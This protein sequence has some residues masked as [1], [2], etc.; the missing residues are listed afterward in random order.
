MA[1]KCFLYVCVLSHPGNFLPSDG[2]Q[3]FTA[4]LRGETI[5]RHCLV[6]GEP[7]RVA[8][9]Q[10]EIILVTPAMVEA[11]EDTIQAF[12]GEKTQPLVLEE[13]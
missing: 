12:D 2:F 8:T 13:G 6:C 4:R 10:D 7:M 1:R 11:A 5:T 3:E 9:V